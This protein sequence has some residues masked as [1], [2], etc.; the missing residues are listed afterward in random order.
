MDMRKC[1]AVLGTIVMLALASTAA[2]QT[3]K[4]IVIGATSSSSSVFVYFVS[5]AKAI[6]QYAPNLNATVVET[7][8]TID[9]LRRMDRGQIDMGLAT[10][11][12]TAAKFAGAEPFNG[13]ANDKL[14]TLVVFDDLPNM[15]VVQIGRAHV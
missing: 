7:G 8:A 11:E 15:W 6:N 9:N 5:L 3:K 4:Q 14:R 1:T 2:A 13:A 10:Q 12:T